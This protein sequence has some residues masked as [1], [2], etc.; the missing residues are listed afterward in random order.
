MEVL[1]L[2]MFQ[3]KVLKGIFE[4]KGDEE[5]VRWR[6]FIICILHLILLKEIKSRRLRCA[7]HVTRMKEFK[8]AYTVLIRKY[9]R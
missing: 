5:T 1:K 7:V 2:R 4:P 3:N 9:K 6:K 8:N